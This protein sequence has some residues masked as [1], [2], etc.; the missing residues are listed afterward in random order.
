MLFLF[1]RKSQADV[2]LLGDDE[3]VA[4]LSDASLGF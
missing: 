4:A 1:G 3:A 2:E